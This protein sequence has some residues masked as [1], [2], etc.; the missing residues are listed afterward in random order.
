MTFVL[1]LA[2]AACS[3][4]L[5]GSRWPVVFLWVWQRA[6]LAEGRRRLTS[7]ELARLELDV[8]VREMTDE[9]CDELLLPRIKY[10]QRG[11][12]TPEMRELLRDDIRAMRGAGRL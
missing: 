5:V 8:G 7:V 9:E 4:Y 12:I 6:R 2:L 3:G 1:E 10:T 11:Y